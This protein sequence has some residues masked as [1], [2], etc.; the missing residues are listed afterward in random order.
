MIITSRI[1]VA[2]PLL[3]LQQACNFL[4]VIVKINDLIYNS[5]YSSVFK[6]KFILFFF[7]FEEKIKRKRE[8]EKV[9]LFKS[10]IV[11][12]G[13]KTLCVSRS[14][15]LVRRLSSTTPVSLPTPRMEATPHQA[16]FLPT[17]APRAEAIPD[18][19]RCETP[20]SFRSGQ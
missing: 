1:K 17:L 11:S 19:A 12:S 20:I 8:N 9:T 15:R 13:G 7:K 6:S 14:T 3:L 10:K 4:P 18:Q 16:V 5:I 2:T